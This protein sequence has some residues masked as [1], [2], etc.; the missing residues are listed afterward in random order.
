MSCKGVNED[1]SLFDEQELQSFRSLS[2]E[3]NQCFLLPASHLGRA[4]LLLLCGKW[5]GSIRELTTEL[6]TMT[7]TYR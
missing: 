3:A 6:S 7:H 2:E 5:I 1:N 4:P